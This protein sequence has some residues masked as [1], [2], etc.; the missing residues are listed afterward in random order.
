MTT[1]VTVPLTIGEDGVIRVGKT[2]VTL[3]TVV[4]AFQDG[5]TAEEIASQYPSLDLSDVYLVIAYYLKHRA[6]VETYLQERE[7]IVEEVRQLNE[8]RFNP[9][10]VRERLVLRQQTLSRQSRRHQRGL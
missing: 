9:V 6:E 4:Y 8:S 2:R 10:G 5:A 3:D 1:T 7:K